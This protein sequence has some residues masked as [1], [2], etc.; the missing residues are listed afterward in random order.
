[1]AVFL[2]AEAWS[3]DGE[4]IWRLDDGLLE[5]EMAETIRA[6]L[7]WSPLLAKVS[8]GGGSHVGRSNVRVALLTKKSGV[9]LEA[10]APP[11]IS[12][13]TAWTPPPPG[14]SGAG[15][16]PRCLFAEQ[17]ASAPEPSDPEEL[18]RL[19]E[20]GQIDEALELFGALCLEDNHG[21]VTRAARRIALHI[22]DYPLLRTD[23]VGMFAAALACVRS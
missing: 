10:V 21:A 15:V 13:F 2:T 9:M 5:S 1:M 14:F 23:R 18:E 8:D 3:R 16:L 6:T 22:S 19:L 17:A 20:D 11:D 7:L 12:L 4:E